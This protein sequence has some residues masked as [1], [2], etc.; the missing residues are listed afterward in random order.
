MG[1][2]LSALLFCLLVWRGGACR[3]AASQTTEVLGPA[4]VLSEAELRAWQ[5]EASAFL[6]AYYATTPQ[7][8]PKV[9]L[10]GSQ[11]DSPAGN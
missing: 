3:D 10:T 4:P 5:S 8:K 11:S 2:S 9:P 1:R 7:S 6:E